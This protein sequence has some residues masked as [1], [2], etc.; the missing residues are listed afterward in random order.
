MAFA[1][2]SWNAD[3]HFR[4]NHN[5]IL[6]THTFISEKPF[7]VF[8]Y[9]PACPLYG[10][11]ILRAVEWALAVMFAAKVTDAVAPFLDPAQS[12]VPIQ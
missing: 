12:K 3:L 6:S 2:H 7:N 9:L 8:L 10:D 11:A 1:M 4:H 5:C